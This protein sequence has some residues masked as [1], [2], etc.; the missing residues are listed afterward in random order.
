MRRRPQAHLPRHFLALRHRRLVSPISSQNQ[1]NGFHVIN[2]CRALLLEDP[3]NH[4]PARVRSSVAST[5]SRTQL[6]LDLFC[7]LPRVT[8]ILGP[9]MWAAGRY[10]EQCIY[11]FFSVFRYWCCAVRLC[12][13]AFCRSILP[14]SPPMF[15]AMVDRLNPDLSSTSPF[16]QVRLPP[17]PH[18][19]I[20]KRPALHV[21]R[22]F[23]SS[24]ICGGCHANR[25]RNQPKSWGNSAYQRQ[26]LQLLGPFN[27]GSS[28]TAVVAEAP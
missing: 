6:I 12:F 24:A 22:A 8:H 23:A 14:I 7:R 11:S 16:R 4:A 2:L 25:G 13:Y 15:G 27:I 9:P 1:Q 5:R 28:S 17:S 10:R 19:L 18:D 3:W 20:P 26:R 21:P